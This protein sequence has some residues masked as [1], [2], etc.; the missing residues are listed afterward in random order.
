MNGKSNCRL[1]QSLTCNSHWEKEGAEAL[2][3]DSLAT[4]SICHVL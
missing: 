4:L 1:K 2:L 3:F